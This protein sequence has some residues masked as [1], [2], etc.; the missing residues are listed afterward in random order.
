MLNALTT[1]MAGM[2]ATQTMLDVTA[3]NLANSE[4]PG[5]KTGRVNF[6]DQMFTSDHGAQAPT[7]P[8]GGRDP[9]QIGNG[10][11][12]AGVQNMFT[13]GNTDLT[14]RNLDLMINGEAFFQLQDGTGSRS[15]SRVG[16]FGFDGGLNGTSRLVDLV[17][18]GLVLNTKGETIS[19]I[20]KMPA[21]ATTALTLTGNLPPKDAQPLH[22][23]T[24]SSLFTLTT[25]LGAVALGGTALAQTNLSR[26]GADL[27]IALKV[28][29]KT[30]DGANYQATVNLAAGA[31]VSDLVDGLNQA[32]TRTIPVTDSAGNPVLDP[33][34]QPVTRQQSF[35]QAS[36]SQGNLSVS[37]SIPGEDMSVFLGEQPIPGVLT[38]AAANTW[39]HGAAT[40]SL[41]WD[42]LRLVPSSVPMELPLYTADGTRQI[43]SGRWFNTGTVTTGTGAPTDFQRTWDLVVND[44]TGAANTVTLGQ[45]TLRGLTFNPDGSLLSAPAG[46][47]SSTWA[48]GGASSVA[49][50]SSRFTAYQGDPVAD[51]IDDTGYT[52]GL[53]QSVSVTND[54]ILQGVYSNGRTAAMSATDHQIGLITFANPGGLMA[55]DQNRWQPTT[56]SG[57][58]VAVAPGAA[59]TNTLTPGALESSNVDISVEF[60]RLIISQRGFQS[61][62][63][64]FQTADQILQE[65]NGLIR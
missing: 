31:T 10:S 34:G 1:S 60:T 11:T 8:A 5:F 65:A 36:L 52:S 61:N 38:D 48:T 54:G 37:S 57:G 12:V 44:P 46:T 19:P 24:L 25:P 56:N 2:K 62:S 49:L 40:D 22:G 13:Q 15:Y 23:T 29:G 43:L 26:G 64:A 42:R 33:A 7:G 45:D 59:G 41:S 58:P 20:E 47:I 39:Q 4:T 53:L 51:A 18:G 9:S 3:N 17:S 32:F 16:M 30:P 6:A 27:P 50:D 21:S 35:A 14:G 63:K 55:M 28:F